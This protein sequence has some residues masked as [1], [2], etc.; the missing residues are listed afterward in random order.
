MPINNAKKVDAVVPVNNTTQSSKHDQLVN[1]V[2]QEG[3][4]W[5]V[6]AN[7]KKDDKLYCK[8]EK[9]LDFVKIDSAGWNIFK[10]ISN[11][12][13]SIRFYFKGYRSDTD[14][15]FKGLNSLITITKSDIGA[16]KAEQLDATESKQIDEV[17]N[18]AKIV[19][20]KAI[21]ILN[22]KHITSKDQFT[23]I[24]VLGAIDDRLV[25]IYDESAKDSIL[26]DEQTSG[27]IAEDN[28]GANA[29]QPGNIPPPPPPPP[30]GKNV[31]PPPP[32]PPNSEA[33]KA[34]KL[35][36]EE[37]I[38]KKKE[39]ER[40]E[41]IA[42]LKGFQTEAGQNIAKYETEIKQMSDERFVKIEERKK[43]DALL[44]SLHLQQKSNEY[45]SYG[46]VQKRVKGIEHEIQLR[47]QRM[48]NLTYSIEQIME[49]VKKSDSDDV[50]LK[51]TGGRKQVKKTKVLE[52][53]QEAKNEIEGLKKSIQDLQNEAVKKREELD[54]VKKCNLTIA[55]LDQPLTNF[56]DLDAK[57]V[58]STKKLQPYE[59]AINNL[60]TKIAQNQSKIADLQKQIQQVEK[61]LAG[62]PME[63]NLDLNSA[64]TVAA[65]V[66]PKVD[67]N[68]VLQRANSLT[69]VI[70]PL[71]TFRIDEVIHH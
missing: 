27:D 46:Q 10:M 66:K 49:Q 63:A 22:Q 26:D 34:L 3:R 61:A 41:K 64:G 2:K 57:I 40:Q 15:V 29:P 20:T 47:Q 6:L 37:E 28:S 11:Q 16:L 59:P 62:D 71:E 31:P 58:E 38:R 1:K 25:R 19:H 60:K 18:K 68:S 23:K 39:V 44:K 24:M 35:K 52:I 53:I 50:I 65:P 56:V 55:G 42:K 7:L 67:A 17:L 4:L 43:L 69:Q 70:L 12:Y 33:A 5:E 48:D 30:G 32:P 8:N 51:T 13:Q 21:P 36:R 45:K 14:Q 54:G 9:G